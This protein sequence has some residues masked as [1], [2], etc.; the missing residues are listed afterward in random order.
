[1]R[2]VQI[3]IE[4]KRIE[5][6]NDE[7]I[8]IN[9]SVQNVQDLAKI[10]T[11]FTQS[12]TVPASAYNNDI[13]QHFYENAVDTARDT[14]WNYQL[15]KPAKIE[16]DLIPFRTGTIQLEKA[17]LK[18]GRPESYTITFYGEMVTLKD[19]FG[20]DKLNVLDFS[21][22]SHTYSGSEVQTRITSSSNYDIRYPLISSDRYWEYGVGGNHDISI[23]SGHIHYNELFP[24]LRVSKIFEAIED[25]YNITWDS[26]FFQNKRFTNLYLWLKNRETFTFFTESKDLDIT[27]LLASGGP[28]VEQWTTFFDATNNTFKFKKDTGNFQNDIVIDHKLQY[29][30]V[31]LSDVTARHY[32]EV[33]K[34]GQ[35][36][37]VH[38]GVGLST[39]WVTIDQ[40]P[41]ASVN[42]NDV[43]TFRV[44]TDKTTIIHIYLFYEVT[45]LAGF[46]LTTKKINYTVATAQISLSNNLDV[47][48]NLP[49]IKIYD[50]ISGIFKQFNLTCT[51]FGTNTF[52]VETLETWYAIGRLVDVT[53]YIDIDSID[54]ER[55]KLFKKI[56]FAH[57]K[58]ENVKNY[59]IKSLYNREY[60]DLEQVFDYDGGEYKI[61]LPYETMY[62]QLFT[63]TE[64]Q[65]GYSW[66]KDQQPLIP[67][68]LIL[69][70]NDQKPCSFYLNNGT[71]TNHITTYM[72]FGQD[73][74]YQNDKFSLNFGYD[75]SSLYEQ[76]VINN[77]YN[78]YYRNYLENLYNPKQRLTYCKGIFP[79]PI[80]TSLKLNDRLIIRDKRYI[81]NEIKTD[82]NTG[83]V[84]LVLLHDFRILEAII[85]EIN[86]LNGQTTAE[87][88]VPFPEGAVSATFNNQGT[89]ITSSPSVLTTEGIFNLT[90]PAILSV[91]T[92]ET[93]NNV[94]LIYE[95]Y[96]ELVTE[97]EDY[98][99][100]LTPSID[101]LLNNGQA[102]QIT[103][104][105]NQVAVIG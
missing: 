65:V 76:P 10:F 54:I 25:K 101:Y 1:M 73:L 21:E 55:V 94:K 51:P 83:D 26:L 77:I 8:S 103:L 18:N 71:I 68:C 23:T 19:I 98:N 80:L 50:F 37:A 61:D 16:I 102:L 11:E 3:Y 2:K 59:Q 14:R 57:V 6:F 22:Y 81:I 35:I 4:G 89:G 56:T 86:L 69:Y 15:R 90:V 105:L 104:Q 53:K 32:L 30:V 88:P 12:F 64:L 9:M 29:K 40:M 34:N 17:N 75:N 45:G 58:S 82:L 28:V 62:H 92:F 41:G 43:Y 46:P 66:D 33:Y 49:D 72:P 63:G 95:D 97:D 42:D 79:T 36:F 85:P 31:N 91:D 78:V 47:N 48:S 38:Q 74:E 44:Y 52:K 60:G 13:F 27:T 67:K 96:S 99:I 20:E 24:A 87:V 5:L 70:M 93:E 39:S 7:K 100:Y 84:D